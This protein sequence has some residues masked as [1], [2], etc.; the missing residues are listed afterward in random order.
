MRAG[1][2]MAEA[3]SLTEGDSNTMLTKREDAIMSDSRK[4]MCN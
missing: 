3:H 4:E 1:K 2:E